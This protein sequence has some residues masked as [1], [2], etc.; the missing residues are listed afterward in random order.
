VSLFKKPREH[1][2]SEGYGLALA[3]ARSDAVEQVL[4]D[5]KRF[6]TQDARMAYADRWIGL[7]SGY[8]N[9]TWPAVYE[10][11]RLIKEEE[12][13]KDPKRMTGKTFDSFS[14]YF[15]D[16]LGQPLEQWA[17]LEE[18]YH[19]AKEFGPALFNDSFTNARAAL[20]KHGGDRK[21][22]EAKADQGDNITLKERGTAA[23]Y[24]I[25]RLER[26]HPEVAERLAAGEFRSVRAAA[27]EAGVVKPDSP[28]TTIRRAW[29]RATPHERDFI[30]GWIAMQTRDGPEV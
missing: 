26:D 13:Y 5:Y 30:Q 1:R 7:C 2:A 27:M 11:L 16:R 25:A 29:N 14:E 28:L 18:T 20:G 19:Y 3:H 8:F 22:E 15:M 24:L 17:E 6:N 9:D 10:L 23:A 12:L 4:T 21:S